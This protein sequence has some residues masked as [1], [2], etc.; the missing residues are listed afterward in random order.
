MSGF[1]KLLGLFVGRI[2]LF[3]ALFC[4]VLFGAPFLFTV[5]LFSPENFGIAAGVTIGLAIILWALS[6]V[7]RK[8]WDDSRVRIR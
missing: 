5:A 1:L 6:A 2:V 7:L 4:V 8:I 3:I